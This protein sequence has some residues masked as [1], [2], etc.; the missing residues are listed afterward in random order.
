MARGGRGTT[1]DK[2]NTG[3]RTTDKKKQTVPECLLYHE[4][5]EQNQEVA[6]PDGKAKGR[7]KRPAGHPS[8]GWEPGEFSLVQ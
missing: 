2:L 6:G 8:T 4:P 1:R 3:P 7:G 5:N